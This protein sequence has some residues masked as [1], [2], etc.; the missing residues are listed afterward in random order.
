MD[1][2]AGAIETDGPIIM[3]SKCF[4]VVGQDLFQMSATNFLER[5]RSVRTT[6]PKP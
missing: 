1:Q 5:C 4:E 6:V 2:N 3:S